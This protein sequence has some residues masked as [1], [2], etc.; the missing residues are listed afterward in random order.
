MLPVVYKTVAFLRYDP[1]GEPHIDGFFSVAWPDGLEKGAIDAMCAIEE[2]TPNEWLLKHG[3]KDAVTL[4][5]SF[6]AMRLRARFNLMSGPYIF[7]TD[8]PLDQETTLSV[9]LNQ[10]RR[11]RGRENKGA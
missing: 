4:V 1:E 11:K 9:I 7:I 5:D 10:R 6:E 8:G 2:I 3:F